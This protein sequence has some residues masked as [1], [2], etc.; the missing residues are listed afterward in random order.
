MGGSPPCGNS[1]RSV[2][3]YRRQAA[4]SQRWPTK[5]PNHPPITFTPDDTA[6]IH[7]PHNDPL[8]VVL[9]IGEYDVTKV[10]IDTGSSVDLI[11]RGTLQMMG[12][13]LND[14]KASTRT[15]TGFNGFSE[16]ILGTIRLPVCA[17]G[18]TRMVKFAVV[19]TKAPYHAILGTPWI[20][21]MQA[22]PSTFHQCIK[23]PGTNR[24]IKT[25]RGDQPAARDL[26][27][28]TI[29]LQRSSLP[30]NSISPPIAKVCPQKEEVLELPIDAT[31]PS[32]TARIG[33]Y[34]SDD[35][36]QSILDFLKKNISTFAW[37][38][39][40]MKGIDPAITM[41]ELNVDPTFKP[42]RQKRRK[43]GPD[44]SKAVNEEVER[45]L[46]AG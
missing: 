43:L 41:H 25:L 29:K 19:S 15:L 11:F 28:T 31:Y 35:M 7:I 22:V 12:V 36:Q 6:G 23:F 24:T 33:A 26:L 2:K 39:S 9:G 30:V 37:S 3:D 1:V 5:S 45:L 44:R 34:L 21:S 13:D 46:G 18:V 10:L 8:L 38:M 32:R 16:T 14:I 20:H 17:C 40:D 27:I 42:I 4:T